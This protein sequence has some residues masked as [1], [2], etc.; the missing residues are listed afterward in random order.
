MSKKILTVHLVLYDFNHFS[1]NAV[2][3]RAQKNVICKKQ[4]CHHSD[5]LGL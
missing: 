4:M 3:L 5:L 2:I 1:V